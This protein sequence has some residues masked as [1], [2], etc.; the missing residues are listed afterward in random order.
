MINTEKEY[1]IN[2]IIKEEKE[3]IE[4]YKKLGDI[5][6]AK[7]LEIELDGYIKEENLLKD[8]KND[9]HN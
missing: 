9:K 8:E 3:R 7:R 4:Y 6:F 5:E 2:R 1:M